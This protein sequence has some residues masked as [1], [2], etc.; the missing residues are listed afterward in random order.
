[1]LNVAYTAKD[2]ECS[3]GGVS[4]VGVREGERKK[5]WGKREG[6]VYCATGHMGSERKKDG[7]HIC[8]ENL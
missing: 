5:E 1:M 3:G 4:K 2:S 6:E 8:K 7:K